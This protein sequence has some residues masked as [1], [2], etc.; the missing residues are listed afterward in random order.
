MV[1]HYFKDIKRQEYI[2]WLI[3]YTQQLGHII[4]PLN[5]TKRVSSTILNYKFVSGKHGSVGRKLVGKRLFPLSGNI[6]YLYYYISIFFRLFSLYEKVILILPYMG[7]KFMKFSY[8]I[9]K[10]KNKLCFLLLHRQN[11]P[12]VFLMW[13]LRL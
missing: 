10:N 9:K 4:F 2:V 11:S 6:C 1:N 8:Q 13:L 12:H 7:W 3:W 5:S